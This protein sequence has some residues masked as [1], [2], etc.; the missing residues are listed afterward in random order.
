MKP[1]VKPKQRV[2]TKDPESEDITGVKEE[3][4]TN[5]KDIE[6]TISEIN[7]KLATVDKI[8]QQIEKQSKDLSSLFNTVN[9]LKA[10]ITKK[11]AKMPEKE[12]K[13]LGKADVFNI[14]RDI[15]R[16]QE[17]ERQERERREKE[18][19]KIAE[20]VVKR[21]IKEA[22]PV[23]DGKFCTPDGVCYATQEDLDAA[24]KKQQ[25]E[26]NKGFAEVKEQIKKIVEKPEVKEEEKKEEV[27]VEPEKEPTVEEKIKSIAE[28]LP[29]INEEIRKMMTKEQL[30]ERDRKVADLMEKANLTYVDIFRQLKSSPVDW[31]VVK[32]EALKDAELKT[33][34][35][36]CSLDNPEACKQAAKILQDKGLT[37]FKKEKKTWK[38]VD[39]EV[40]TGSKF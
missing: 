29:P 2:S 28:A 33:K 36:A 32:R 5:N 19:Q 1:Y 34:L 4:M 7:Q 37:I 31:Q 12:E 15:L 14:V 20:Q 9:L 27:K 35:D 39:E 3:S 38:P 23:K 25:E 21:Q 16:Q 24:L 18:Q 11:E 6:K 13:P 17:I 30:A 10:N 26:I 40:K 8:P 22:V